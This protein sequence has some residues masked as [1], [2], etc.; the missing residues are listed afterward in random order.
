MKRIST[1]VRLNKNLIKEAKK[2]AADK[3]ISLNDLFILGISKVIN[4][5]KHKKENIYTFNDISG[6]FEV[7]DGYKGG[8]LYKEIEKYKNEG[9]LKDK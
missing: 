5:K 4:E 1:T 3:N 7:R 6:A 2:T 9:F 8:K